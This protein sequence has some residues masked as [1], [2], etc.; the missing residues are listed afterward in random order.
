[1]TYQ[2][3]D[4]ETSQQLTNLSGYP[5]GSK[6]RCVVTAT[7]LSG[8]DNPTPITQTTSPEVVIVESPPE[9]PSILDLTL[10]DVV[11]GQDVEA[12]ATISYPGGD[13]AQMEA[14]GWTVTWEWQIEEE[15][16]GPGDGT[17]DPAIWKI[18]ED[19]DSDGN[20]DEF[21]DEFGTNTFT[22][23]AYQIILDAMIS[24]KTRKQASPSLPMVLCST[25]HNLSAEKT[26]HHS[27]STVSM[28]LRNMATSNSQRRSL[29]FYF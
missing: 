14:D 4:G 11:A 9:N 7:P 15:G 21:T 10:T 18:E 2:N 8:A 27:L 12:T 28:T 22:R 6:I 19:A 13:L 3:I 16:T 17:L 25:S 20:E 24:H 23:T 5:L 26:V 29:N 1:M